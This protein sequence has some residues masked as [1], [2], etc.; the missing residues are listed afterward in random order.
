M[1]IPGR[2]GR[3]QAEQIQSENP[4]VQVIYILEYTDD[5]IS[6]YG[7]LYDNIEYIEKPFSEKHFGLIVK[8]VDAK[9]ED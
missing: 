6:E 8:S 3:K 5:T 9:A 2:N 1:D 4:K 7:I